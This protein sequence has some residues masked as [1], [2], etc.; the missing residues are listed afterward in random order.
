MSEEPARVNWL[1]ARGFVYPEDGGERSSE[2]SVHTR[3]TR[4]HIP[5]KAFLKILKIKAGDLTNFATYIPDYTR[6]NHNGLVILIF[7]SVITSNIIF[8]HSK[9]F[10]E[11]CN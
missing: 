8:V 5:T 9:I 7:I 10:V 4:R 6:S 11:E 1:P 2:T 3:S